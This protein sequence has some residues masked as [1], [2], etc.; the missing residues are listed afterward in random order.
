MKNLLE[1][2]IWFTLQKPSSEV[3][4]NKFVLQALGCKFNALCECHHLI[5]YKILLLQAM[6]PKEQ[7]ECTNFARGM[8]ERKQ[9]HAISSAKCSSQMRQLS[10]YVEL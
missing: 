3:H 4:V 9:C 5:A 8:L 2:K 7:E 1:K 6:K 10:M